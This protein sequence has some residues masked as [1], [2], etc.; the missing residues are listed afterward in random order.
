[1]F[2]LGFILLLNLNRNYPPPL[3]DANVK[4]CH[5]QEPEIVLFLCLPTNEWEDYTQ[6]FKLK[7]RLDVLLFSSTFW[8][9]HYRMD[10]F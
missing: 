6:K 1:M 5:D 8:L 10:S 2:Y 4:H 7:C 9:K 3:F